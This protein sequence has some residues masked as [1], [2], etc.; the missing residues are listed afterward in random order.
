MPGKGRTC[1]ASDHSKNR[2]Q[3]CTG[4]RSGLTKVRAGSHPGTVMTIA[5]KIR[6]R[7]ADLLSLEGKVATITGGASGI[8]RGIA[9]RLAEVGARIAV[10]DVDE[11]KGPEV[12][13]QIEKQGGSCIFLQ[14]DV[15]SSVDCRRA[16]ESA[17]ANWGNIDILCN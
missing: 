12:A 16:V 4:G 13:A 3:P 8:G 9:H 1:L 10:L 5:G 6:D 14:C 15:R 17:V 7:A 2:F 11:S